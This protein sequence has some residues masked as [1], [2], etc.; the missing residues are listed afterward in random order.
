MRTNKYNQKL[1]KR[2]IAKYETRGC[3]KHILEGLLGK[4]TPKYISQLWFC[5]DGI[6]RKPVKKG[7]TLVSHYC[8]H[9]LCLV[10]NRIRTA[11]AINGYK[12][13]I[14]KFK[15][16]MFVTLTA[17]TMSGKLLKGRIDEMIKLW[18]NIVDYNQKFIKYKLKGVRKLEL[19]YNME[20][21]RY[22]PHFHLILN[23]EEEA[24]W[25]VS[26]WLKRHKRR[27]TREAQDI[28]PADERSLVELFK[29]F[30]KFSYKTKEGR[31]WL[32]AEV[33]D[34]MVNVMY[35]RRTL[36]SFGTMKKVSE[37][38]ATRLFDDD[39]EFIAKLKS[40]TYLWEKINWIGNAGDQLV[41]GTIP[42]ASKELAKNA[43]EY[44][45]VRTTASHKKVSRMPVSEG[46]WG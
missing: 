21:Q 43:E 1:M 20:T 18:Q 38:V 12:P 25:V 24:E 17:R 22:H 9:R 37:T 31:K 35:H 7:E 11:N 14:E 5:A 44:K 28:R 23:G 29:Y 10:C 30:S 19:T 40:Q 33:L 32:P 45:M 26:A 6:I 46:F 4:F 15:C 41:K 39:Q 13:Q 42:K 8:N 3:A 34:H 27:A 36:Q 2:R 16:P